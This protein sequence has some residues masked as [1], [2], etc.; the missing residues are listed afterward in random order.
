MAGVTFQFPTIGRT[1]GFGGFGG[2]PEERS[3]DELKKERDDKLERLEDLLD[4]ARAYAKTPK[5]ARKT[6][7]AL[8]A[9]VP[10]VERRLPLFT[11]ASREQDIRDAVAFAERVGVKIVLTGALEAP[12]VA[13]LLK[14]RDIPVILGP[15][16]TLP[17]REDMFH[18]ATYQAAGE[19]AR[20]GVKIAFATGDYANVRQLPYN[21]AQSVAWGLSRDAAIRALTIDAADILGVAGRL[22]SIEPGKD[23]NLLIAKGDPL[24]ARTPIDAVVIGGRRVDME[25]KHQAL[26]ERYM[27]RP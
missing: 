26:F 24:E 16:L 18:A 5:D 23:A 11:A 17:G 15:V 9:L 8:D 10:V 20:A 13:S 21:A 27:A 2:P 22:G 14:E 19:L 6:D 25:N 4:A 3:Y 12:L 7:W 1:G